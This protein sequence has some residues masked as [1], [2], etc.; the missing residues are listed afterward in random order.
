[1]SKRDPTLVIPPVITDATAPA[2]LG[3][4]ARQFR[5]AVARQH[6]PFMKLGQ[7]TVV[8]V[9][10]L[11]RLAHAK[12]PL[13]QAHP[14]PRDSHNRRLAART[15]TDDLMARIEHMDRRDA[16]NAILARMGRQ[17][18]DEAKRTEQAT[19]RS[20]RPAGRFIGGGADLRSAADAWL[21][22]GA[23][24]REGRDARELHPVRELQPLLAQARLQE[25][26]ERPALREDHGWFSRDGHHPAWASF[27]DFL[28]EMAIKKHIEEQAEGIARGEPRLA[29]PSE[30]PAPLPKGPRAL[31]VD[32]AAVR[33]GVT[34]ES[35]LAEFEKQAVPL[36]V[37]IPA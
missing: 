28:V 37:R 6:L 3:M 24:R 19:D 11:Q 35:I 26:P 29:S 4:S 23:A 31:T 5:D 12:A 20:P 18:T 16:V 21:H 17:L 25:A 13:S 9:A 1:M 27:I 22:E 10:D 7:R 14:E 30:S 36:T 33:F 2:L 32:E 8:L 15:E 34:R